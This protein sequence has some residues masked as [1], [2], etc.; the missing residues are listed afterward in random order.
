MI[1]IAYCMKAI[2]SPTCI[3]P[4]PIRRPP[5]QTI[6]N[7]GEVQDQHHHRHHERHDSVDLDRCIGQVLVGMI[8]AGL[9][10]WSKRLKERMTRMPVKSFAKH[11]IELI[12]FHLH[13]FE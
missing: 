9:L 7:A 3:W 11:Q 2:R 13:N 1:C 12:D 5:N 6:A 8:E 10:S 4:L